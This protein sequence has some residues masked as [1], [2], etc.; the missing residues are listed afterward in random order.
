MLADGLQELDPVRHG[1]AREVVQIAQNAH[2]RP[3]Q[4]LGG[5]APERRRRRRPLRGAVRG[6]G[7]QARATHLHELRMHARELVANLFEDPAQ[8]VDVQCPGRQLQASEGGSRPHLRRRRLAGHEARGQAAVQRGLLPRRHRLTA[9]HEVQS[10]Q[11]PVAGRRH[12]DGVEAQAAVHELIG[13]IEEH[14]RFQRQLQTPEQLVRR[15]LHR[16]VGQLGQPR[17][18]RL[19]VLRDQQKLLLQL[20]R[21]QT[22]QQARVHQ[23]PH[24]RESILRRLQSLTR[25]VCLLELEHHALL[26]VP[27]VHAVEDGPVVVRR[28]RDRVAQSHRQAGRRVAHDWLLRHGKLK[29][30]HRRGAR[31]RIQKAREK[32]QRGTLQKPKQSNRLPRAQN[33]A[34]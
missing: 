5:Q 10:A 29:Q 2:H 21:L 31:S 13:L 6:E 24:P 11:A 7:V 30:I 25:H 4:R 32:A 17:A 8:A 1:L 16:A 23:R 18:E 27:L 15:P 19:H 12:E 3:L 14:Q 22:P 20:Q 26:R 28:R 33:M 34:N 9:T